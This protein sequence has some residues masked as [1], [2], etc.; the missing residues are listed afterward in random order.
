MEIIGVKG[1]RKLN[2]GAKMGGEPKIWFALYFNLSQFV[3]KISR[4]D[5]LHSFPVNDFK[6]TTSF[7]AKARVKRL[8]C[9]GV[10]PS[11]EYANEKRLLWALF[12]L[13]I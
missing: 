2:E 1:E 8:L 12:A 10:C 11:Q 9:Q 7:S 13:C 5:V 3:N 6:N 4:N